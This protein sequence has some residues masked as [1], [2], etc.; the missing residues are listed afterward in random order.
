MERVIGG[1]EHRVLDVYGR[2][3]WFFLRQPLD[4]GADLGDLPGR[5]GLPVLHRP[6]GFLAGR[7]QLVYP[8]RVGRAGRLL[9]RSDARAIRTRSEEALHAESRR[10]YDLHHD[11]ETPAFFPAN[12]GFV[13]AF[14]KDPDQ[15]AADRRR[16]RGQL[17]GA[18]NTQHS[19]ADDVPAAQPRAADQHRRHGQ[20][21]G[22]IRLCAFRHRSREVYAVAGK[23]IA[24]MFQYPGFLFR[25]LRSVQSH[26][27]PAGEPSCAIRPRLYGVS[28]TRIL[29][30]LHNAYS[31]NYTYLIKKPNDQYQVILE[32]AGRRPRRPAESGSAVHQ[33]RRRAAHGSA[34]AP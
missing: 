22:A 7:R 27:E 9:A 18:I 11:A 28:E 24:K 3:L 5:H 12:Q 1:V 4:L 10:G 34:A 21:A 14:L 29:N 8:R 16:W 20:Y 17:M 2:S 6:Q 33:E 31:Q 23:L 19:R 26:A 13:L 30:L 25:Q 15:R 32:V